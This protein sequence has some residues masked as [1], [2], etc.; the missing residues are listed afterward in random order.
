MV[1]ICLFTLSSFPLKLKDGE[2]NMRIDELIGFRGPISALMTNLMW[3]LAFNTTYLG[4]FACIPKFMGNLTYLQYSQSILIT[5]LVTFFFEQILMLPYVPFT[6]EEEISVTYFERVVLF[7]YIHHKRKPPSYANLETVTKVL[8]DEI[9][10]RNSILN[11]SDV[12]KMI[13][14]YLSFASSIFIIRGVMRYY[15]KRKKNNVNPNNSDGRHIIP[16]DDDEE[17]NIL[18]T[19]KL[20]D[21]LECICAVAKVSILI[22]IKMLLFPF[23]IGIWLDI[24]TLGLYKSCLRDRVIY[25]GEDVVGF[26]LLHWAVGITF[27][28][29]VTISVLQFREVLHPDILARTVKPQEGQTDMIAYLLQDDGWT[30]AKR[31]VPSLAIYVSLLALHVWLPAIIASQFGLDKYIPLF[32]PKLWYAL[33]KQL[34]IPVELIIF[35]LIMNTMVEKYKNSIGE[36]QHAFLLKMCNLLGLK[37]NLLPQTIAKFKLLATIPLRNQSAQPALSDLVSNNEVYKVDFVDPFWEMVVTLNE[38]DGPTEEFINTCLQEMNINCEEKFMVIKDKGEEIDPFHSYIALPIFE[39]SKL[40]SHAATFAKKLVPPKIGSYRFR[41]H[42]KPN[43][44]DIH[45]QIWQEVR[46]EAVPRPP[47]GW[48]YMGDNGGAIEQGRWAW[49]DEKMSDIENSIAQRKHLFPRVF[50]NGGIL[51]IWKSRNFWACLFPVILRIMTLSVLS[52]ATVSLC[53][54]VVLLMPIAIGRML[55]QLLGVP[56]IYVHDPFLFLIGGTMVYPII[57]SLLGYCCNNEHEANERNTFRKLHLYLSIPFRKILILIQAGALWLLLAPIMVGIS[58]KQYFLEDTMIASSALDFKYIAHAWIIGLL[59]LHI[60]LCLHYFGAFRRGFLGRIG[61]FAFNNDNENNQNI[62]N[63]NNNVVGPVGEQKD[64]ENATDEDSI[65]LAIKSLLAVGIDQEFDKINRTVFVYETT[66]PLTVKL[67]GI[68]IAPFAVVFGNNIS[69][70]I[71]CK[72]CNIIGNR[73]SFAR[74]T[75]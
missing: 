25:A 59:L 40:N 32:H 17:L 29:S 47:A 10:N 66:L 74:S 49:G 58:Y 56:D 35:H 52:W 64:V 68:F 50:K 24:A 55:Y 19:E 62:N 20:D 43:I 61:Q 12:A 14:G 13:L 33:S 1:I 57:I 16:D 63:N 27:M 53:V 23:L 39:K 9:E 30:H 4:V 34:Q 15:K 51:P 28:L 69:T 36:A 7:P 5:K 44:Q 38:N 3:F 48:D 22:L 11:I 31:F 73:V 21:Y 72:Y 26:F 54:Y 41:K 60:G 6:L 18:F 45:I 70:E 67:F 37:D 65:C 75:S 2:M 46:G 8:H 42:M 71:Q